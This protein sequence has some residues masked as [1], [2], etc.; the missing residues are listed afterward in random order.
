MRGA[1][2]AVF[3]IRDVLRKICT[4]TS[5]ELE[6]KRVKSTKMTTLT[7]CKDTSLRPSQPLGRVLPIVDQMQL[8]L[9][10]DSVTLLSYR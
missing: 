7:K 2:D 9:A 3:R 1:R 6:T 5:P 8:A 10:Y 4:E